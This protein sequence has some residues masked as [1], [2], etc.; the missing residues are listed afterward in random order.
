[1]V[2]ARRAWSLVIAMVWAAWAGRPQ[3]EETRPLRGGLRAVR[4][5]DRQGAPRR[6]TGPACRSAPGPQHRDRRTPLPRTGASS[7]GTP[8]AA[9]RS[10]RR[11]RRLRHEPPHPGQHAGVLPAAGAR[12]C[13]GASCPVPYVTMSPGPTVNV[14]G[15]QP[16]QADHRRR[17]RTRPTPPPGDLRLT[18]VSVT[19][20]TRRIG[21]AEALTA[22][23]DGATRGLPARRDLPAGPDR[24]GRAAAEQRGDGQLAGHRDRG[25]AARARLQ[26]AAADRG[27]RRHQGRRPADGKLETRR[28]D[29]ARSTATRSSDVAAGHR[30]DPAVRRR[31]AG[32]LRRT[33]GSGRPGRCG[34]PPRRPP[35][36][37][38]GRRRGRRSA[39]ATT[40]RS[41][42]RCASARTSAGP[43]AGLIFSPRR[44]RHAHPRLAD[45]R[46]RHRRH[47]NHRRATDALDPSEA[48]S[49]RS[50][51]P[52]THGAKI[53][54][55]PPA[56]CDVSR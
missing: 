21:L 38:S 29:P 45:R 50:S 11:V 54:L 14:L 35:T 8:P 30:G 40:S 37:R 55:V 1:M 49:R 56:N 12:R 47:G 28:P 4:R 53:F 41:T 34:S 3:R 39:P 15:E 17:R 42:C 33:P 44:L 25:G 18:T 24:R 9:P 16:G 10:C 13:R 22:W 23:F 52:R 46:H 27:A 7:A 48:S 6:R 2:G 43:S 32:H 5:G 36:T 31:Q 20:P 51:R 26:A 19:N